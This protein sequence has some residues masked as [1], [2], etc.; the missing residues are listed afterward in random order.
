MRATIKSY[1]MMH[2]GLFI[3]AAGLYF[4]L[5]P[6]NLA[7]GGVT[8]L[9]M[10]LQFFF[11]DINL[12]LL[13]LVFNILLFG[14]AFIMIGKAFGSK[15]V[16]CSLLLSAIMGG[17]E[18]L[19][20][21]T[22]PLIDDVLINLIFGIIIQGIGMAIVFYENAST[23]GTDI[24]AKIINAFTGIPI[25][26]ALFL[27]DA[28]ITLAAGLIFGLELGLYAF[29]GILINGLLIDR[30]IESF[31]Q[32]VQVLIVSENFHAINAYIN[33]ELVRGTTMFSGVG[34]YSKTHKNLINV[35]LSKKEYL[36]LK[37]FVASSDPRAFV[38][39]SMV[40]EVIGEGFSYGISI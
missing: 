27:S 20:P 32:K 26:K 33:E 39:A 14:L 9:A 22:R 13:M 2:T 29:L 12:G 25:G 30:V 4:F 18:W 6:A 11:N 5:V 38:T 15:T 1:A 24:V 34:G 35:V 36:K 23:G 31:D 19:L 28:L 40:H 3:M 7:V 10:V 37:Q 21:L 16:Y 17:F 8:G